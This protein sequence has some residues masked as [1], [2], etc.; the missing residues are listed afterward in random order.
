MPVS[1]R[2]LVLV[3]AAPLMAGALTLAGTEL[4]ASKTLTVQPSGPRGGEPG[5][6]FVNVEGKKNDKYASYAVLVFPASKAESGN[7]PV[8]GLKLTLTQS[9]A[10]F[11]KE[12]KVKIAL[13]ASGDGAET[14][15]SWKFD[16]AS[17]DGLG[18][19]FKDRS[20]VGSSEFK[21]GKSGQAE[22]IT[23]TLDAVA[24]ADVAKTLKAG[25]EIRL[26]IVPDDEA[27]AATYFGA[28]AREAGQRPKLTI[29]TAS[30]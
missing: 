28:G 19:R 10:R 25:G 29:E 17:I 13:L 1:K 23:L 21:P 5:K 6:A 16:P 24:K 26:L 22:S 4:A 20:A 27:V 9:I 15:A 14:E 11:S 30:D 8:T 12:G 3:V 2:L 7:G 18:G